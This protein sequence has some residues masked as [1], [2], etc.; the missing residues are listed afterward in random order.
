MIWNSRLINVTPSIHPLTLIGTGACRRFSDEKGALTGQIL[1]RQVDLRTPSPATFFQTRKKLA[2][3]GVLTY[4]GTLECW[5]F[6]ILEFW[7]LCFWIVDCG[8]WN[9]GFWKFWN[10]GLWILDFGILELL[11]LGFL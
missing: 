4:A 5:K 6:E 3:K 9:F 10:F 1:Q 8:F 11:N 2:G 7:N